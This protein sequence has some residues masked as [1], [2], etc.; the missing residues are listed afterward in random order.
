MKVTNLVTAHYI[1]ARS[2]IVI[3]GCIGVWWGVIGLPTFWRESSTVRIASQVIAGEPFRVEILARQLPIIDSIKTSA[4]C[5]PA[6]L[7]SAAIIQLRTVEVAASANDHEHVD[8]D[9]T[10]LGNMIRSSLSCSPADPFLWLALYWVEETKHGFRSDDLKYLR[11]SYRLGPNEGWIGIKRNRLAFME[12]DQ[13]P[14]DLAESTINEFVGLAET[15]FQE[16]IAEIF[17]GPARNER[18]A[19]LARLKYIPWVLR[20]PDSSKNPANR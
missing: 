8:K 3:A 13:L 1:L 19:I 15:N 16:Q 20:D 7:R 4:Y 12:F 10:S 17:F 5:R 6:A 11:M 2:F 9:L 14:A 18:N